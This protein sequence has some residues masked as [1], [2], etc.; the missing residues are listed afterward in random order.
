MHTVFIQL[1]YTL[2][3]VLTY[4]HWG[5]AENETV[6]GREQNGLPRIIQINKVTYT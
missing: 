2:N 6:N 5:Q 3:T 4:S 1:V